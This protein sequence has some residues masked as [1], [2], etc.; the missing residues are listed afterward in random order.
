MS[1]TLPAFLAHAI[2]LESE[3]AER[4]EE[5][6]DMMEAHNNQDT[7]S[8]FREM[9]KFSILHANEVRERAKTVELPKLKSWEYRWTTPPEVGGDEGVTYRMPPY[10]AL[11]YA[12]GNE[13]RGME[14]YRQ[15]AASASDPEVKRLGAEFADEEAEHVAALDKWIARTQR[16]KADWAQDE[17][18]AQSL[19]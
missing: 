19:D 7:A 14:F 5:L 11:H 6:A 18:P 10:H 15:A 8:V 4:Y 16:P 1:Y 13:I 17:E 9:S 2:A 3:A 12:L